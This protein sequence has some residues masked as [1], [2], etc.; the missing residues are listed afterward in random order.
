M[1]M[2]RSPYRSPF[3]RSFCVVS[4]T[5]LDDYQLT[6]ISAPIGYGFFPFVLLAGLATSPLTLVIASPILITY[7]IAG[8]M[9]WTKLGLSSFVGAFW[10]RVRITCVSTLASMRQLSFMFGFVR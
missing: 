3:Q 2:E 6:G 9:G 10:L 8:S 4:G 7:A 1:P 5:L